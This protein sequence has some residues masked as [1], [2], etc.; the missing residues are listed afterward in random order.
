MIFNKPNPAKPEPNRTEI[1]AH[2]KSQRRKGYAKCF[3]WG[4]SVG[5]Y[6]NINVPVVIRM[7]FRELFLVLKK[8]FLF[9]SSL[10]YLC[11]FAPLRDIF[12]FWDFNFHFLPKSLCSNAFIEY[13]R[14][15]L[16]SY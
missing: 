15:L 7:A 11:A 6:P 2:A 9:Y 8:I 5:L 1:K 13:G 3:F 16:V 14:K 10:R 4:D 12:S